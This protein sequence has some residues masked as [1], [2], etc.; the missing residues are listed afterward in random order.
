[1]SQYPVLCTSIRECIDQSEYKSII[2]LRSLK[3]KENEQQTMLTSLCG[4]TSNLKQ[5]WTKLALA[6]VKQFYILLSSTATSLAFENVQFLQPCVLN[7]DEPTE[8][9]TPIQ[10]PF[11]HFFIYSR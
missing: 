4:L 6:A 9:H 3:R 2:V 10:M 5:F 1:I 8:I 11:Q 7:K